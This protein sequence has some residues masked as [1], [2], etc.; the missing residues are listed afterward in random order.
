LYGN[1]TKTVIANDAV[2]LGYSSGGT[3]ITM[4]ATGRVAIVQPTGGIGTVSNTA[5]GTTVTGVGT[6]FTRTF[7]VGDTITIGAQTVA[8]SAI[9]SDTSMT[10]AAITAANTT[11][12]Y[13][14]VGGT[15]HTFNG[16][17]NATI[18]NNAVSATTIQLGGAITGN[19][20]KI[21]GAA[22]GTVSITTDVTTG[23]ANVFTSLTTGTLNLAT[24]G[25]STTNIGGAAGVLNIG[26]TAGNS[27]VE[28]RGNATTGTATIRTNTGVTTAAVFNTVA[29]TGNLFG[30]ATAIT[31]G[32]TTGTTTVR[33]SLVVTGDLTINGTTTTVNASTLIVDDKNIE[34]GS[35]ASGTISTTGTVGSITG[36]GPWTATITGMTSTAGLVVGSSLAATAGTG[37]LFGGSPTS[38]IVASIVSATSITYTV[39]GGTTPTAG[40]VTTITTTGATD[41]T[42][43]GG[44]ITL[45]GATDKTI[46]WDSTAAAWNSS[47]SFNLATGKVFKIN[48]NTILS[49]TTLDAVTVDGGTY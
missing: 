14:L 25:A 32:A 47:E 33:N 29:T 40:T 23:I 3:D 16:S 41:V 13:T 43:Q 15:R 45:K 48:G 9:A 35:V 44:G 42:A 27:I 10:T 22:A 37:T 24:G 12:A 28:V 17:G 19:I 1:I 39:T 2:Q 31:I 36:T 46:S 21:A 49:A 34:L 4:N 38:V 8:I 26:T 5:L 20:V 6:L 7:K 30:A 18:G 11:V